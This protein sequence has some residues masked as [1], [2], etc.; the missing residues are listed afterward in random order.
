MAAKKRGGTKKAAGKRPLRRQSKALPSHIVLVPELKPT[1][2]AKKA[3]AAFDVGI[4]RE[5][6]KLAQLGVETVVMDNGKIVRAVPH[7]VNGRFVVG[8]PTPTRSG[9]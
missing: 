3:L 4:Q 7:Q 9:K 1:G 8:E 2:Y 5:Y 6:R